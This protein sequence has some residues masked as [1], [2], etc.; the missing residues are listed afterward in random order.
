[1][2]VVTM[3]MMMMMRVQRAVS[4]VMEL[5]AIKQMI[6]A[7]NGLQRRSTRVNQSLMMQMMHWGLKMVRER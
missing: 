5:E 2:P 4:K 6:M 7:M 1:M 3:T